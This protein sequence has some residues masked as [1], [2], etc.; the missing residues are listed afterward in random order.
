MAQ[1]KF[2]VDYTNKS[3]D[4]WRFDSVG[5][6]SAEHFTFMTFSI[7]ERS[8]CLELSSSYILKA[9]LSFSSGVLHTKRTALVDPEIQFLK[10]LGHEINL[11]F[12]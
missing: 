6:D 8:T 12:L 9:H 7:S 5:F 3:P 10:G 1:I 4:L 2:L 11:I